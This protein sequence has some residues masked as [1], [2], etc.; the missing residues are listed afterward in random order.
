MLPRRVLLQLTDMLIMI[1]DLLSIRTN[2]R[3]ALR[4]QV[5]LLLARSQ[6][7]LLRL[8]DLLGSLGFVFFETE[9]AG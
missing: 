6:L 4:L 9:L 1:L 5:F 8:F 7:L 2:D 3:L